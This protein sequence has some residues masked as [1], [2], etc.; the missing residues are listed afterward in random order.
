MQFWAVDHNLQIICLWLEKSCHVDSMRPK[1][2][3]KGMVATVSSWAVDKATVVCALYCDNRLCWGAKGATLD[4]WP[5]H[6]AREEGVFLVLHQCGSKQT[7]NGSILLVPLGFREKQNLVVFFYLFKSFAA[8]LH[9]L[10]RLQC[11]FFSSSEEEFTSQRTGRLTP[12][13]ELWDRREGN[14]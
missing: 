6:V 2:H 3:G 8:P 14:L 13:S 1:A 12:L 9:V 7:E 10:I 11:I 5:T 4:P